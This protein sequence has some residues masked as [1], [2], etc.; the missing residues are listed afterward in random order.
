MRP[1]RGVKS[2]ATTTPEDT[3]QTPEPRFLTEHPEAQPMLERLAKESRENSSR[4]FVSREEFLA[5]Y[6]PDG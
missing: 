5:E 4:G 2:M 6:L 3:P 1:R